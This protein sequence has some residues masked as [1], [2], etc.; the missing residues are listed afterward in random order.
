MVDYRQVQHLPK[1]YAEVN[2]K[3]N[4]DLSDYDKVDITYGK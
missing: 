2:L 4:R 3:R 1:Y